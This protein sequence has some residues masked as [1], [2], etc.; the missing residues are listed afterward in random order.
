MHQTSAKGG[1]FGIIQSSLLRLYP[2]PTP[3]IAHREAVVLPPAARKKK[4]A[5][6]RKPAA[7][8]PKNK[9]MQPFF[10]ASPEDARTRPSRSPNPK[11]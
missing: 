9:N 4:K 8:Q 3:A 7:S 1:I 11:I 10:I 2:T 5:M 6:T